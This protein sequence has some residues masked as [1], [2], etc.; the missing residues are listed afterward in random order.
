M[1][2]AGAHGVTGLLMGGAY[3]ALASAF[4][5]REVTL[6]ASA[7]G[8]PSA[9]TFTAQLMARRAGLFGATLAVY[10][11]ARASL[12]NSRGVRDPF[13][14]AAAGAI[15]G[16]TCG[17]LAHRSLPAAV[18]LSAAFAVAAAVSEM[19]QSPD[20]LVH[21][22]EIAPLPKRSAEEEDE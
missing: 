17:A 20:Y 12:L 13:N 7:P 2:Q 15:A 4:S 16:A 3:G 8:A 14:P 6:A 21:V 10:G 1:Y 5:G 19:G 22:G 11:G 9:A 18:T